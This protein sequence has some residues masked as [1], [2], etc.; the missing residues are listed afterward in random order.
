MSDED[1]D[2]GDYVQGGYSGPYLGPRHWGMT[3]APSV[4]SESIYF[5]GKL[6]PREGW[7][8]DN[9]MRC[10]ERGTEGRPIRI[11]PPEDGEETYGVSIADEHVPGGW[12]TFEEAA[13]IAEEEAKR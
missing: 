7:R 11:W 1:N 4:H 12:P 5:L 8:V 9:E 6:E 2:H 13:A 10:Y 3:L